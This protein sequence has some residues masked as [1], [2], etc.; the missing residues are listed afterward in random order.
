M[1]FHSLRQETNKFELS[2]ARQLEDFG[3]DCGT[4]SKDHYETLKQLVNESCWADAP[5]AVE[6][7]SVTT[8]GSGLLANWLSNG[9]LRRTNPKSMVHGSRKLV[10]T[11]LWPCCVKTHAVTDSKK[12]LPCLPCRQE[13]PRECGDNVNCCTSRFDG[14][15]TIDVS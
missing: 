6:D 5:A 15:Q 12:P 11:S 1:E 10:M 14:L 8:T 4:T 2:L 3:S 7:E 9:F 13:R